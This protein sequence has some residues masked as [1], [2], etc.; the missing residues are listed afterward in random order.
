MSLDSG[1]QDAVLRY[2]HDGGEKVDVT[3]N[4]KDFRV[5]TGLCE[6]LDVDVAVYIDAPGAPLLVKPTIEYRAMGGDHRGQQN[7]QYHQYGRGYAFDLS[8]VDF[9]AELVLAS[10]PAADGARTVANAGRHH[11][12]AESGGVRTTA[13]GGVWDGE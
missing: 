6:Q 11:E 5:M 8:N 9:D 7:Q 10:M 1:G 2:E 4:L 3:V 12:G 13:A